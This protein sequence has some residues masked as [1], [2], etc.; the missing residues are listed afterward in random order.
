MAMWTCLRRLGWLIV[1]AASW[2]ASAGAAAACAPRLQ[3]T[4]ADGA[5]G[6]LED[7]PLGRL[8]PSGQLGSLLSVAPVLGLFHVALPRQPA[9]CA[10][11]IGYAALSSSSGL[12][13]DTQ[14]AMREGMAL[15]SCQQAAGRAAKGTSCE[16]IVVLADGHS[17]LPRAQFEQMARDAAV[18]Q[19]APLAQAAPVAPPAATAPAPRGP[20]S[21]SAPRYGVDFADG[22][23]GCLD[24]SVLGRLQPAGQFGSL[25]Q[26]VPLLGLYHVALPR[27]PAQC[28]AAIGFAALSSSSG[29]THDTQ[30]GLREQVALLSCQQ[31]TG[32]RSPPGSPCECVIVLADGRSP[33]PITRF[34]QMAREAGARA[35]A[36]PQFAGGGAVVPARTGPASAEPRRAPAAAPVPPPEAVPR[37][38]TPASAAP[39]HVAA[40]ATGPAA[41]AAP[42]AG[43]SAAEFAE[44]RQQLARL[45]GQ[46]ERQSTAVTQQAA[47]GRTGPKL[48]TRALV[49]GNGAY[50]GF[51]ALPN[52]RRDA[53]AIAAKLRGFGIDVD[54]VL[55]TDRVRLVRALNEYLATAS[56]TDVNILFYAGHGVQVGGLNYLIPVDLPMTSASV[57]SIRLNAVS[58]NDVLEYL[59]ARTRVVFLDACRDNPLSRSMLAARSSSSVGLAPVNTTSGTL[60]AY[61]TKDGSTAEDGTGRHSPYTTALLEHLDA[62]DDIAV[63]LRRVRQAVLKATN[64]RQEPWEY[65]SLVG[66]ELVLSRLAR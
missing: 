4:F 48:R 51:A 66:E 23:R 16:C 25:L 42:A 21:C 12:I 27:E 60:V 22:A 65:G 7:F 62:D 41:G 18:P 38:S 11:A 47:A 56:G 5:R 64:N 19:S 49:I 8:R 36:P 6:C 59:P 54:L 63:V 26:L 40:A 1:A 50:G 35:S 45:Q 29:S 30:A 24:D 14:V 39:A 31:S 17:P 32:M 34:E 58:L 43:P 3:I 55:D 53:Q 46:L 20:A 37:A 2:V 44:L 57:G 10:A 13:H 33:L 61:A 9:Q 15:Q 28:P 52:P